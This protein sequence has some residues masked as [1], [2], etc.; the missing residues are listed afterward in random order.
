MEAERISQHFWTLLTAII[1]NQESQQTF[2]VP[3]L[4]AYLGRL[5]NLGVDMASFARE[6]PAA[7]PTPP[8]QPP[9]G[10]PP[11]PPTGA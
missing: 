8:N 5:M 3:A 7:P 1:Q 2:N 11:V 10:Q 4:L 9:E 6:Q